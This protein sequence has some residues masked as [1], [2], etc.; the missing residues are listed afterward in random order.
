MTPLDALLA[1][2][3]RASAFRLRVLGVFVREPE[4]YF[5]VEQVAARLVSG[6]ARPVSLSTLYRQ[7]NTLHQGGVLLACRQQSGTTVFR[8]RDGEPPV[9]RLVCR[10]CGRIEEDDDRDLHACLARLVA[11]AGWR[12]PSLPL[13]CHGLCDDC[14]RTFHAV[15][16]PVPLQERDA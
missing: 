2:G 6:D 4:S 10:R 3:L 11:R 8:W 5:A 15:R 7:V 12:R 16:R 13:D 14:R 1:A 9:M